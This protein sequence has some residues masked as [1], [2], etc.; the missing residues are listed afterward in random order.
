MLFDPKWDAEIKTEPWRQLLLDAADLIDR[1][2]WCQHTPR[3]DNGRVCAAEALRRV[4]YAG[5]DVAT[6]AVAMSHLSDF[7]TSGKPFHGRAGME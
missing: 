2:G 5:H 1:I 7:V 4:A 6:Y 3:D